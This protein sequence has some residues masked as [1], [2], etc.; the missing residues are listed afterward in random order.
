M[1]TVRNHFPNSLRTAIEHLEYSGLT[2]SEAHA[3]MRRAAVKFN[4]FAPC[5]SKPFKRSVVSFVC[6]ALSHPSG[7]VLK[8]CVCAALLIFNG[9]GNRNL[10]GSVQRR[11]FGNSIVIRPLHVEACNALH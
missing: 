4:G 5:L 3:T 2:Q 10:R 1:P 11:G 9:P 7:V 6:A 8:R